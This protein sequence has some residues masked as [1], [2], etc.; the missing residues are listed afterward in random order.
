M[1]LSKQVI[2]TL[3][4]LVEIKLS[5][6]EVYDREDTRELEG[7]ER[8]VQELKALLPAS[9]GTED[10][11]GTGIVALASEPDDQARTVV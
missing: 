9:R 8:C 6:F 11:R 2:D 3:L 7:L 4:D 5:C 10:T 1:P